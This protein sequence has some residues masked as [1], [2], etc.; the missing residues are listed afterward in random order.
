MFRRFMW[1]NPLGFRLAIMLQIVGLEKKSDNLKHCN[2]FSA[3]RK[4]RQEVGIAGTGGV[5]W[6]GR[7][8]HIEVTASALWLGNTENNTKPQTRNIQPPTWFRT[9]HAVVASWLWIKFKITDLEVLNLLGF[10]DNFKQF[11]SRKWAT[12][13]PVFHHALKASVEWLFLA[14][15]A[16]QWPQQKI[17]FHHLC[18]FREA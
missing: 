14:G 18:S 10:T 5:H 1:N 8:G 15:E 6:T 13:S 9:Q 11:K 17:A 12:L 16:L 7:S 4:F 3:S 2:D